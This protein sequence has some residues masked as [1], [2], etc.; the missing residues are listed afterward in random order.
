MSSKWNR[1]GMVRGT[2]PTWPEFLHHQIRQEWPGDTWRCPQCTHIISSSRGSTNRQHHH[3]SP[4]PEP[5]PSRFGQRCRHLL[6]SLH[7]LWSV[8]APVE[9]CVC[10]VYFVRQTWEGDQFC[11]CLG[12][13]LSCLFCQADLR[14]RSVLYLFRVMSVMFQ[15]RLCPPD[16][17][18]RSSFCTCWRLWLSRQWDV[19]IGWVRE[20]FFNPGSV[21]V[22]L[23]F[24]GRLMHSFEGVT[25]LQNAEW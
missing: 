17:R 20:T 8:F 19:L 14:M 10:H 15:C 13:C 4:G 3:Y 11:T 23:I 7:H 9:G 22:M 1:L 24:S 5:R 16:W 6:R 12:L 18:I 25:D 21:V 2:L